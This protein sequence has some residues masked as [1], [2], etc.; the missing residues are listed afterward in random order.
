HLAEGTDGLAVAAEHPVT[1]RG[2][3]VAARAFFRLRRIGGV[4]LEE[5]GG[6]SVFAFVVMVRC[7]RVGGGCGP[8]ALA[9]AVEQGVKA[10]L[11]LL[12]GTALVV[13]VSEI[14]PGHLG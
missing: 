8:N 10:A 14:P 2:E 4:A 12:D 3:V 5:R 1:V 6:E 11:R 13:A 7:E 9:V